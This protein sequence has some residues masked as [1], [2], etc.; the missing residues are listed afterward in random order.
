MHRHHPMAA[1][2]IKM[3]PTI[4][5]IGIAASNI[6]KSLSHIVGAVACPKKQA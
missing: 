6:P 1:R 2:C 4:C 5:C 3:H